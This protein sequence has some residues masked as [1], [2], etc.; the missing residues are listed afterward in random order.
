MTAAAADLASTQ[1]RGAAP[2]RVEVLIVGGGPAGLT[3]ATYLRRFHRDCRVLD[4]GDSR[5]RR[6]PE[7]HNCPGFPDGVSGPELLRRMRTQALDAGVRIERATVDAVLR[8]GDGFR[9]AAGERNWR[10]DAVILAT[11]VSDV[12][13]Q[14]D[15]AEEAIACGAIRLCAICDAFEATDQR[16]GVYGPREAVA[17]HARFLRSYTAQLT[18]MP[19][20][21]AFDAACPPP[22]AED[23]VRVLPPGGALTFDGER[24]AYRSPDGVETVMDTLYPFLGARVAHPLVVSAHAWPDQPGETVVD[25]HQM[26]RVPGLYAIG[27]MVSGLNQISVAVGQAAIAATHLHGQLPFAPRRRTEPRA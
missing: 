7:S 17:S 5:A 2:P 14:V 21:Q 15:W 18:L 25:A 16:I 9:V 6:I 19:T 23:A 27:D 13:P 20:D 11:G 1:A 8:E 22:Y 12:L 24:C 26:T 10:A 4:G 3:A